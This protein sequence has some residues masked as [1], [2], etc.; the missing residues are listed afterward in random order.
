M[1]ILELESKSGLDRA[2]I[3]H[4]ENEGLIKPIRRENGYRDYSQ[5]NLN[6]LLKIKL[7]RQ[8]GMSVEKIRNLQQGS[9]DFSAALAEQLKK[10]NA[11]IASTQRARDICQEMLSD[12]VNYATLDAESYYAKL[13]SDGASAPALSKSYHEPAAAEPYHPVRRLIARYFDYYLIRLVILAFLILVVRMRPIPDFLSTLIQY[14]SYFIAVPL[15]ALMLH[16]FGTTPGKFLMGLGVELC[17][18][19]KMEYSD[20]LEREWQA[21]RYGCGFG[22]PI[23][24]LYRLYKSYKEYDSGEP[25]WDAYCEYVYHPWEMKGK[26][27]FAL[28]IIA[29]ITLNLACSNDLLKP[30]YR[31]DLTISEYSSNY[32]DYLK[33]VLD[34]P[35]TT[36]FLDENGKWKKAEPN[37][38]V[39]VI[40]GSQSTR[41]NF[42]FETE[43]ET[44]TRITYDQLWT[45]ISMILNPIGTEVQLSAIAV[46]MAQPGAGYFEYSDLVDMVDKLTETSSGSFM[47]RN[48]EIIW[49]IDADN[50]IRTSDGYF[51]KD[52]DQQECS[53]ALHYEII[54]H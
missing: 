10:L 27:V 31:G 41:E 49:E 2:T 46:V 15:M 36:S 25:E 52:D 53:L 11:Q 13:N 33:T 48:V 34:N 19:G 24:E 42:K 3:R 1:L 9:E 45:D 8:L 40:I 35:A 18:G 30:K 37:N 29:V 6:D 28:G 38:A 16:Y 21:L 44:I 54:I 47:C 39:V 22:I 4:Y 50:C 43:G 51:L 32:N 5:E 14:G 12:R 17:Y 23:Y 7:L 26:T 20:A